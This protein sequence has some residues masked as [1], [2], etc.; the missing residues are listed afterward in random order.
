[1]DEKIIM[2]DSDESAEFV[3]GLSGWIA[4]DTRHFW[5]DNEDMARWSGCTH[6]VCECGEIM[7]KNYTI[8]DKCKT[9]SEYERY[10]EMPVVKWDG[11]NPAYSQLC[12]KYCF[13]EGDIDILLEDVD[14]VRESGDE[15]RLCTYE[16]LMLVVCEPESLN[17]VDEDFFVDNLPEEG[18]IS[19]E[20]YKA[21]CAFNDV[22][23]RQPPSCWYPGNERIDVSD[24]EEP[25]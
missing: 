13:D 7:S 1:M 22:I 14:F 9:K 11:N 23:K 24:W 12:D 25:K 17:L 8:C 18:E 4:S 20:V 19:E 2:Y 6:K 21:M 5:G 15:K 10:N 16:E 3:T